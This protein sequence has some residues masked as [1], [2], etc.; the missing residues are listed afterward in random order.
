MKVY[1]LEDGR[2][3]ERA[4]FFLVDA[5]RSGGKNPKPVVLHCSRV[6]ALLSMHD[7][8]YETVCAGVLHDILEDTQVTAAELVAAFGE[9][10]T[11]IVLANTKR[12]DIADAVEN[13]TELFGRAAA[14]G[15]AALAVK[16]ADLYDNSFYYHLAGSVNQQRMLWKKVQYFLRIAQ[17]GLGTSPVY[18]LLQQQLTDG[19]GSFDESMKL[20]V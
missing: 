18:A 10:I 5:V 3:L 19:G 16:A 13:Y 1:T 8:E 12:V 2:L 11:D 6:A 7:C 17:P 15:V 14:A 4:L 20:T 9:R